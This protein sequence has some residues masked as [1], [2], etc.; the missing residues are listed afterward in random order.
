MASAYTPGLKIVGK[1][2]V[3]K[4]R[5]LPMMGNVHVKV[6][7]KVTA[8]QVVASTDLPGKCLPFEYC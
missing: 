3:Q 7:D 2:L 1:T 4:D 8:E 5:R 6:G